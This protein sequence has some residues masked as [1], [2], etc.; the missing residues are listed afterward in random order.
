MGRD[1]VVDVVPYKSNIGSQ[2]ADFHLLFDYETVNGW[3]WMADAA[4]AGK[5]K[6][7]FADKFVKGNM[8]VYGI[9]ESPYAA[10]GAMDCTLFAD[11]R[12]WLERFLRD[13]GLA[14]EIEENAACQQTL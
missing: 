11:K 13:F 10:G 3:I 14:V 4:E 2:P 9:N 12:A 6:R 8:Y 7:L 5:R 1:T